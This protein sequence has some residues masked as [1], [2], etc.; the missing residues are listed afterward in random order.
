M[1]YDDN[2]TINSMI[3]I[4]RMDLDER[5]RARV[6]ELAERDS[7]ESLTGPI[8]GIE[9]EGTLLAATS[10]DGGDSIA[11]PF[12]RTA[13]LRKMLELRATQLRR[14]KRRDAVRPSPIAPR[15]RG[16][17]SRPDHPPPPL[18]LRAPPPAERRGRRTSRRPALGGFSV[19]SRAGPSS[20]R[21]P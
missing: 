17:A 10:L 15:G 16:F 7:H 6:A 3:T 21:R 19:R 1:A 5:D 13:E 8:L 9:V 11:D 14:R 12:S 2:Q 4:R 20:G 18:G